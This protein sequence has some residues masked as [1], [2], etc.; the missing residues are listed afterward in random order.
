MEADLT[1]PPVIRIPDAINP[2]WEN[3]TEE[4]DDPFFDSSE[5]PSFESAPLPPV[6]EVTASTD[7]PT[8]TVAEPSGLTIRNTL[9]L[10][11]GMIVVILL[12]APA[13]KRS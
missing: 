11:G 13:R 6:P 3:G 8:V 12:F 4:N 10:V 1:S 5:K 7:S 9:L 2:P